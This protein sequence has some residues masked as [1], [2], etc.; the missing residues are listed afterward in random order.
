MQIELGPGYVTV[1]S[2][3]GSATGTLGPDTPNATYAV[4][5]SGTGAMAS[6]EDGTIRWYA[7]AVTGGLTGTPGGGTQ[8]AQALVPE[9]PM[10]VS[11]D[12]TTARLATAGGTTITLTRSTLV[13][14][15]PTPLPPIPDRSPALDC[16]EGTWVLDTT[17]DARATTSLEYTV[18]STIDFR[19]GV[20]THRLGSAVAGQYEGQDVTARLAG[21]SYGFYDT[22]DDRVAID[23][24]ISAG[25]SVSEVELAGGGST[26][27]PALIASLQPTIAGASYEIACAGDNLVLSGGS[28]AEAAAPTST[29]EPPAVADAGV[30][31]VMHRPGTEPSDTTTTTVPPTTTVAPTTVAPSTT[32]APTTVA[33]T[34]RPDDRCAV[35]Q[36]R[37]DDGGPTTSVAPT[38]TVAAPSHRCPAS[39]VVGAGL[40]RVRLPVDVLARPADGYRGGRGER[41]RRQRRSARHD[42]RRA[43]GTAR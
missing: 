5:M 35:H 42:P 19:D 18:A 32:A 39:G 14:Q 38:T 13:P 28:T 11:C 26:D 9:L 3:D 10:T 24:P 22:A 6:L 41:V 34:R 36:R 29:D 17:I 40:G 30:A 7:D 23:A 31:L 4:A 21:Q 43:R 33:P 20:W 25:G 1:S 37:A 12:A 2:L 8:G 27:D 15:P 16:L